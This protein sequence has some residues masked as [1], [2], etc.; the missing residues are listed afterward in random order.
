MKRGPPDS[1]RRTVP[2]RIG[3]SEIADSEE[4]FRSTFE[5][6]AV[7]MAHVALDG[8]WLRVNQRLCDMVG[9]SR[10]E[11][12]GQQCGDIVHPDDAEADLA[13]ADIVLRGEHDSIA[14]RKRYLL[15]GGG[16]LWVQATV[17][18]VRDANGA[19]KY[20]ISV[21]EDITDRKAI[22][23]E[24]QGARD[25]LETRVAERTRELAETVERLRQAE[26]R[27]RTVADFTYDWEY[28]EMPCGK[29]A[30]VSP[31]CER[32]TGYSV[33]DFV[34]DRELLPGIVVEE[35]A[36]VWAAHH[37]G[38]CA[39]RDSGTA[40]FRIR[41][42][43]GEIR[44]IEHKCRKVVDEEGRYLGVR[45]SNRDV[46]RRK[47]IEEEARRLLGE[48]AHVTRVA[49]LGELSATLAH[50]INQ[51]LTAVMT[52][53]QAARRFLKGTNLDRAK[54]LSALDEIVR[55]S[56]RASDVI[57]RVS[58][59]MNKEPLSRE[60]LAVDKVAGQVI[61]LLRGEFD[62]HGVRF[63]MDAAEGLPLVLGD[64]VQLQQVFLNLLTNAIQAMKKQPRNRRV[65]TIR[66]FPSEPAR[67]TVE[68][69]D[70][71][72]GI[73]EDRLAQVF[74]AFFT[75]KPGGMGVGLAINRSIV[76]AHGGSIWAQNNTDGGATFCFSL[77][78]S[79][80]ARYDAG[81]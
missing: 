6:A 62:R 48:L 64:R 14:M 25:H 72:E 79:E 37:R 43:D 7:G 22:E 4:L 27:Y 44:W 76:E 52:N 70:T 34:R 41:R 38:A 56:K 63:R 28:W 55:S 21:S 18:L 17:S 35:D 58:T 80:T 13:A 73:P 74:E 47:S 5:Q 68:V 69:Q 57:R 46:T 1:T 24:L 15:K 49:A 50:E 30:Y 31:A 36:S 59:L 40:L 66:L 19:P 3:D 23:H 8:R 11:L 53:A 60:P 12:L 71:G 51:P 16:A 45:A 61:V 65:L 39:E 42:R 75:T 81:L 33:D 78:V 26:T 2:R 67:V 9:F 20:F 10:E 29:L 77:P 32:I 54:A